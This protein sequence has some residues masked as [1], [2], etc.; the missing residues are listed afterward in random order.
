VPAVVASGA[1]VAE[2]F[3]AVAAVVSVVAEAA[4]VAAAA[5]AA[6]VPTSR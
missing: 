6:G 3:R 4:V 2:D 1:A 5:V